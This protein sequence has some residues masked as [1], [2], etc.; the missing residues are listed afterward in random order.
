MKFSDTLV[1]DSQQEL[2]ADRN[3]NDDSEISFD[4]V[5]ET[6]ET[7]NTQQNDMS[8]VQQC[9]TSIRKRN[10]KSKGPN[11]GKKKKSNW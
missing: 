11:K 10:S 5:N 7:D 6:D 8:V 1:D 2:F 4:D 3:V 9:S